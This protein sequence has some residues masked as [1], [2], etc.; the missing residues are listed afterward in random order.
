MKIGI[1]GAGCVG[2]FVG[3]HLHAA[4]LD[5]LF[6]GRRML[7]RTKKSG[8]LTCTDYARPSWTIRIAAEDLRTSEN[9]ADLAS[10]DVVFVCVKCK[11]TTDVA[12][13]LSSTTVKTVVSLQNGVDNVRRLRQACPKKSVTVVTGMIPY[14]VN[15]ISPGHVHRGTAGNIVFDNAVPKPLVRALRNAGLGVNVVSLAKAKRAQQY[16]LVVN[17]GNALNAAAGKPLAACLRDRNYRLLLQAVWREGIAA[18][19]ASGVSCDEAA[20][21]GRPLKTVARILGWPDA[22]YR[23]IAAIARTTDETYRSSMLVDL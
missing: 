4:N 2:Q 5:V 12:T 13:F 21:G 16:K 6:V 15:E 23:C 22:V 20:I 8:Q 18:V 7:R 9:A 1:Y 19:E 11:D 14:G 3:A 10:C 17:L